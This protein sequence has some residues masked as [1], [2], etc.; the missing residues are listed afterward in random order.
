MSA[1]PITLPTRQK[2]S[3]KTLKN[4]PFIQQ[5][6]EWSLLAARL[7]PMMGNFTDLLWSMNFVNYGKP[8]VLSGKR[9]KQ[10]NISK[11]TSTRLLDLLES[12][13]LVTVKREQRKAPRV[14]IRCSEEPLTPSEMMRRYKIVADETDDEDDDDSAV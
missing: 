14:T 9:L 6:Y 4:R 3:T 12:A 7:H 1:A 11:R 5:D 2:A 13:Q 8:V 10:W